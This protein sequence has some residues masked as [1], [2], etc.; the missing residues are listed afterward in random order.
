MRP[1][2]AV[3]FLAAVSA[4]FFAGWSLGRSQA[5]VRERPSSS[6]AVHPSSTAVE[7]PA[8]TSVSPAA[9]P[10]SAP[11]TEAAAPVP[12]PAPSPAAPPHLDGP[13]LVDAVRAAWSRGDKDAA[14]KL[15]EDLKR[16]IGDDVARAI[17]VIALL[18]DE[19]TPELLDGIF[20]FFS[21][22]FH[23]DPRVR[24]KAL[25]IATSHRDPAHQAK[26]LNFLRRAVEKDPAFADTI[27]Q[28]TVQQFVALLRTSPSEDVR[29][30][31]ARLLGKF[32]ARPG[33]WDAM[34][35]AALNFRDGS[36]QTRE[37][38]IEALRTGEAPSAFGVFVEV[39]KQEPN[40]QLRK[41]AA[42]SL[43]FLAPAERKA[44]IFREVEGLLST[45]KSWD[46]KGM[47]VFSLIRV[48]PDD[49]IGVIQRA[50]SREADPKAKA[51]LEAVSGVLA[52]GERDWLKIFMKTQERIK[53]L[54]NEGK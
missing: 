36:V 22:K 13:A 8:T 6:P 2:I 51:R 3:L 47:L 14:G 29:A 9:G 20:R 32:V 42:E 39:L 28:A 33:V 52:D 35:E 21:D 17:E 15:G 18:D 25:E 43:A 53:R 19:T 26:A 10:E 49:S 31:S 50:A 44:E 37:A 23:K 16:W 30:Q 38:A 34:E 48:S 12:G 7:V 40:E 1:G 41:K 4:A 46:V 54:E 11:P 27:P 45:E 24:A 5:P